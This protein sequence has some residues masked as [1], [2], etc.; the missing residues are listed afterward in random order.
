MQVK[1]AIM[2]ELDWN[3]V[4][5]F[6]A[7]AQSG[8]FGAAA[9][10]LKVDPTTLGRRIRRLEAFLE[11]TLFE[12]TASGQVLTESGEKLLAE[13]ERMYEGA[14]LIG[15]TKGSQRQLSGNLRI[16]VSEG[17]GTYFL[18]DYLHGFA[19][20]HPELT[21][22]LVADSGFLSP[23]K[24]EADI[25]VMLSRPKAGP[26]VA[27]KL[28]DYTLGLYASQPYLEKHGRPKSKADLPKDH[29]FV[30]YIPD[31]LYAPEL[32]YL[33]ELW[34]GLKTHIRTSSIIT[35]LR[36]VESG[37]GI[38]VLP[39]FMGNKSEKLVQI[40]QDVEISRCFWLVVHQDTKGLA[41]VRAGKEWLDQSVR[42]GHALLTPRGFDRGRCLPTFN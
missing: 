18:A 13:A 31:L 1:A 20:N 30:G 3:D 39:H 36:L 6:F 2:Q 33:D 15:E 19:E 8:Q 38:A 29:R 22:E 12:R 17:F 27:R 28:S 5:A 26:V 14:L 21:T 11:Q 41:R 7:V 4:R 34:P 23:S 40:C 10:N 37:A 9:A 25:A 24:R 32:A 42:R 16:S 35:Q